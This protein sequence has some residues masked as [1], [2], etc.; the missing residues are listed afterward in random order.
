[1]L[2]SGMRLQ[3]FLKTFFSILLPPQ[4][5]GVVKAEHLYFQR[6]ETY[7]GQLFSTGNVISTTLQL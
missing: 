3:S 7:P 2:I 4:E 5:T 6:Y 1:M